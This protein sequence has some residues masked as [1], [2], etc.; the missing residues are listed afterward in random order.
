MRPGGLKDRELI[1]NKYLL[2][3][4]ALVETERE[5]NALAQ[6]SVD[7][8]AAKHKTAAAALKDNERLG[9]LAREE[10]KRQ[11]EYDDEEKHGAGHWNTRSDLIKT[12]IK[13]LNM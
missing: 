13:V 1:E 12:I 10:V 3:H 5:Q 11:K 2:Q 9:A 6:T 8:T 7:V 4:E